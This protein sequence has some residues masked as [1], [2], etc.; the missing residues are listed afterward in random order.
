MG[1][2]VE[3]GSPLSTVSA[4]LPSQLESY[5][6]HFR[7]EGGLPGPLHGVS[8]KLR[9]PQCAQPIGDL[10]AHCRKKSQLED[11]SPGYARVR[12]VLTA[13][14][15][16]GGPCQSYAIPRHGADRYNPAAFQQWGGAAIMKEAGD[17]VLLASVYAMGSCALVSLISGTAAMGT[18]TFRYRWRLLR[19]IAYSS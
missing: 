13:V 9:L 11:E 17:S 14:T 5:A 16:T 6:R 12:A 15:L 7:H 2:I 19:I 1:G 3:R 4:K 10:A 18:A 8:A